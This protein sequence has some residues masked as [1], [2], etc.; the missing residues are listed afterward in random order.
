MGSLLLCVG[1]IVVAL[2]L[3]CP[4][5]RGVLVPCPGMEP[6]SPAL[7]DGVLTTGPQWI[8]QAPDGKACRAEPALALFICS[9]NIY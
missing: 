1:S 6:M 2:G 3:G 9:S 5:A 8:P 7:E 4:E